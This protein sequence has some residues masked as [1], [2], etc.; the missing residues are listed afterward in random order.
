MI[1]YRFDRITKDFH[2]VLENISLYLKKYHN[3]TII[4]KNDNEPI[5]IGNH[6]VTITDAHLL[7]YYPETDVLKAIE[8]SDK[9][10]PLVGLFKLRNNP[11]DLLV[12]S[13]QSDLEVKDFNFKLKTSI[14]V[15][16]EP[17]FNLDSFYVKRLL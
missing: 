10:S 16:S 11:N 3:A 12:Y 2:L 5:I 13:Q 15:P 1:V 8:F 9:T 6:D 14:Y 17:Y 4:T 7:I